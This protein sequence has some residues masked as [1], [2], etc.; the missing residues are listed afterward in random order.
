M[1]RLSRSKV[2]IVS[3]GL[4]LAFHA[5]ATKKPVAP[6]ADPG[7]AAASQSLER[8]KADAARL[9]KDAAAVHKRL[10]QVDAVA[11][12]LPGLPAFRAN[13]F[14][15]DEVLGG[16]SGTVEYLSTELEAAFASGD[17]QRE[18]KVTATI[19]SS[20]AEMTKFEKTVLDLAHALIPF[21]RTVAQYRALAAA[22]VFFTRTLP[23]GFEVRAANGGIEQRLLAILEAPKK[24]K[25]SARATGL[26]FDRLWFVADGPELDVGLSS[27]QLENVA[28]IL[29]AHP[30]VKLELAGYTPDATAAAKELAAG[31]ARAVRE[32]LVVLGVAEPRLKVASQSKP[33]PRCDAKTTAEDCR[34]K[35]PRVTAR[36]AAL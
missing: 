23:T 19:T 31:R 1:P 7:K 32:R 9:Q 15:T 6:Q 3:L 18:E 8:L 33:A 25:T 30:E 24:T 28:A 11:D 13:L 36:V 29:K 4:A 20:A 14:A 12:D 34:A 26:D 2:V 16:V 5:C 21:E 35:Q 22:G 27:E 10:G 17:R